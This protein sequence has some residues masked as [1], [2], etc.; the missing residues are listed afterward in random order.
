[1]NGFNL[2]EDETIVIKRA[3]RYDIVRIQCFE[4]RS[5][6]S[7]AVSQIVKPGGRLSCVAFKI[8]SDCR[9][10][11]PHHA[12]MTKSIPTVLACLREYALILQNEETEKPHE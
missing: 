4:R 8:A 10:F 12:I 11:V 9:I 6:L 5:L 2:L 1:L 7:E 3:E